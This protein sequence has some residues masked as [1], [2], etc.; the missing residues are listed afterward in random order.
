MVYYK[1]KTNL[2]PSRLEIWKC[3]TNK[4]SAAALP[5]R[6]YAGYLKVI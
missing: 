2:C 4:G 3:S 5:R 1:I 6:N